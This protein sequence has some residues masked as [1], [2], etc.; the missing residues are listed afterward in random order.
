MFNG[1]QPTFPMPYQM[2]QQQQPQGIQFVNGI[3]SA[4]MYPLP[5]NSRQILMDRNMARFYMVE[6]DASGQRTVGAYDFR[7][8]EES[9]PEYAT[10]E[11]LRRLDESI[12]AKLESMSAAATAA[13]E[14][15]GVR[16]QDGPAAGQE[17]DGAGASRRPNHA[18]PAVP[19]V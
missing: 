2:P 16:Q 15:V 18:K 3:D 7:A 10:K 19:A 5:P 8:V 13:A 6:S 11:D 12:S 17:P 1:Y 4:R 14:P 9:Q